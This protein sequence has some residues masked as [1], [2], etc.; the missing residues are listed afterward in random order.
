MDIFKELKKGVDFYTD[1]EHYIDNPYKIVS[2]LLVDY[3]ENHCHRCFSDFILR[4]KLG[5]EIY[6]VYASFDYNSYSFEFLWDWYEGD[7]TI[8]KEKAYG[9]DIGIMWNSLLDIKKRI[10]RINHTHTLYHNHN[11]CQEFAKVASSSP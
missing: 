10:S 3:C 2:V 8:Q 9:K 7:D 4:L 1:V 5:E 11:K 6:N